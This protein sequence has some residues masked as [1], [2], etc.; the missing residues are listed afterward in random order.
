MFG[1]ETSTA[2]RAMIG[3]MIGNNSCGLHSII[4]GDAR[5]NLLEVTAFLS[6]GSEVVFHDLTKSEFEKKCSLQN[7]EGNIYRSLQILLNNP[8]N[9]EAI[10]KGF[11]KKSISFGC[12]AGFIP[13]RAK[14]HIQ[15]V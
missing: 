12:F 6:D 7:L 11:P 9:R 8:D 15:F 10:I 4:W 5:N 1:P 2:N 3:G 14:H 13:V